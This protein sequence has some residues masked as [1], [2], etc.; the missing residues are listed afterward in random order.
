MEQ[1]I[2]ETTQRKIE[3]QLSRLGAKIAEATEISRRAVELSNS[4]KDIL[5]YLQKEVE[6]LYLTIDEV[7]LTEVCKAEGPSGDD[8]GSGDSAS[9]GVQ[10]ENR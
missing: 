5:M 10:A 8:G 3:R 4:T 2:L 7:Y 1:S 9:N 6:E